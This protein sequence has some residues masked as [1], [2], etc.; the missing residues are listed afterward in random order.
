MN[1]F[2]SRT[3]Y[4]SKSLPT[5]T[6]IPN[7]GPSKI[8]EK[9]MTDNP[10]NETLKNGSPG[11]LFTAITFWK[12]IAIAMNKP[13]KDILAI[14]DSLLCRNFDFALFISF[15]YNRCKS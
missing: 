15:V 11:I 10:P 9:I 8:E 13:A 5:P 3:K 7:Q 4:P 6:S 1:G 12:I 2:G 14:K